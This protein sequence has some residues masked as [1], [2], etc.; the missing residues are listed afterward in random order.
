MISY[1]RVSTKMQGE[2]GLGLEA[3]KQIIAHFHGSE[4]IRE[5]VEVA[6][7]KSVRDRPVL[8]QAIQDALRCGC[9]LVVAKADRLSRDVRQALEVYE[10]LGGQLVC[11]D[12]PNADKFTLTLFFAFAERERE[13]ISLRTKQALDRKRANTGEWRKSKLTDEGRVKAAKTNRR[14]ALTNEN[15]KR[16][17][18]FVR[19][20]IRRN[21]CPTYECMAWN[22]NNAGFRTSQ[23]KEFT[24]MQAWRLAR[25]LE[26]QTSVASFRG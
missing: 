20:M 4:L 25:S 13:L 1:Y 2:S 5:Y 17:L 23:G 12:V 6:S 19:E 7:G 18:A 11:C 26:A 8:E 10:R 21:E 14:K 15:N 3:Q 9:P 24:K 16:A 22:L